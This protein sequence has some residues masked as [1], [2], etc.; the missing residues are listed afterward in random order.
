VCGVYLPD[1]AE[2]D[3][4]D[5]LVARK[6]LTFGQIFGRARAV[7]HL[8]EQLVGHRHMIDGADRRGP[9]HVQAGTGFAGIAPEHQVEANLVRLHRVERAEGKPDHYKRQSDKNDP[10]K[11]RSA[12]HAAGRQVAQALL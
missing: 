11:P 5:V 12:T 9:V 7:A 6:H 8:R 1:H 10:A 3:A 4:N 2:V